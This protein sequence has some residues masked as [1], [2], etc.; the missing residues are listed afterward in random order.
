MFVLMRPGYFRAAAVVVC[1]GSFDAVIQLIFSAVA[2][3]LGIV[4]GSK[5]S[6]TMW[7][8]ILL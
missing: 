8:T 1:F 3:V 2:V 7:C 4:G 5:G 6:Y